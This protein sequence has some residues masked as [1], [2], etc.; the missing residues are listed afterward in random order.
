[1]KKNNLLLLLASL[2]MVLAAPAA[3]ATVAETATPY[4]EPAGQL[5]S[6]S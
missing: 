1:M 5:P 2:T 3:R 6:P 4:T